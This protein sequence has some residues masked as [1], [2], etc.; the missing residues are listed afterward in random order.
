MVGGFQWAAVS[1]VSRTPILTGDWELVE[2]VSKRGRE[3]VT[4]VPRVVSQLQNVSRLQRSGYR[5]RMY[6]RFTYREDTVFF[7]LEP[8]CTP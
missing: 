7:L 5:W 3:S 4:E 6:E 8:V 2:A 1:S